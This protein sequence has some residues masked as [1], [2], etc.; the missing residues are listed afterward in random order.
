MTVRP[1]AIGSR[2][3]R[4]L[5]GPAQML[6]PTLA[7]TLTLLLGG[8]EGGLG[9]TLSG[10]T[11]SEAN[12]PAP[13]PWRVGDQFR[14]SNPDVTWRVERIGG[15]E[16]VWRSDRGDEAITG[17][18][19]IQPP[20]RWRDADLGT[21]SYTTRLQEGGLFPLRTGASLRFELHGK[22][23]NRPEGWTLQLDCTAKAVEEIEVP[24]GRFDVMRIE[25]AG[26]A[27]AQVHYYA[28][29]IGHVV[30]RIDQAQGRAPL[31]RDLLSF[32]PGAAPA[33]PVARAA[34]R[35]APPPRPVSSPAPAPQP[36]PPVAVGDWAVHLATVKT[37][38]ERAKAWKPL[39]ARHGELRLLHLVSV[40][41]PS[42]TVRVAAGP[43]EKGEA[44]Q[45]CR[46]LK[47]VGV[48]FCQ[49]VRRSSK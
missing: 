35:P 46:R 29:A 11:E 17:L 3:P 19:P 47:A 49:P 48:R 8:C 12:L 24:A 38:A 4:A 37:V 41:G 21:G 36:A 18:D 7:L 43:L 45:L 16:V 27:V 13:R 23:G 2:P 9:L 6:V 44:D 25:C 5:P 34:P 15:G 14:F 42:G 39:Q 26:P 32:E 1:P 31:V 20:R 40:P 28:P 33:A 10:L 22:G 30:R